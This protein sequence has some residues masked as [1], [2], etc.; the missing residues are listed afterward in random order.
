MSCP[1]DWYSLPLR[2]P[3]LIVFTFS[4]VILLTKEASSSLVLPE[5]APQSS[6]TEMHNPGG[7]DS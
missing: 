2:Q 1:L 6:P 5:A 3:S 7:C 4:K